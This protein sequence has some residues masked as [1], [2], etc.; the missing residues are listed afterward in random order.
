[1]KV[2]PLL[3]D[4]FMCGGMEYADRSKELHEY[5]KTF[6]TTQ[7]KRH[8]EKKSERPH[9]KTMKVNS[10]GGKPSQGW[11]CTVAMVTV[12]GSLLGVFLAAMTATLW[13]GGGAAGGALQMDARL[14]ELKAARGSKVGAEVGVDDGSVSVLDTAASSRWSAPR[15]PD[16]SA[17][18]D[19]MNDGAPPHPPPSPSPAHRPS[20]P[21]ADDAWTSGLCGRV[22][23]T[24]LAYLAN[25]DFQGAIESG[26]FKEVLAHPRMPFQLNK[27][28]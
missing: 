3:N 8:I 23:A 11:W 1:V 19:H 17:T 7:K 21:P 10:E 12:V 6:H 16:A 18:A 13:D 27:V 9:T 15:Q 20:P 26:P 24:T 2:T 14:I 5:P 25:N 4:S 28:R 22:S